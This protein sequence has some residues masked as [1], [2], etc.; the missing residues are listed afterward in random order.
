MM[1][2]HNPNFAP[3]DEHAPHNQSDLSRIYSQRFQ[4]NL[5]YRKKV[6]RILLDDFFSKLI[7]STLLAGFVCSEERSILI[8]LISFLLLFFP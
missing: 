3:I 6:W 7:G 2:L 8:L 5:D 4:K 1:N